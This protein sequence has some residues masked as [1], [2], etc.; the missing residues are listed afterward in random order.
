MHNES[1]RQKQVSKIIQKD[2][3]EIFQI[4]NIGK[5]S[6]VTI[7]AVKSA[8]DLG[9]CRIYVSVF[10]PVKQY[11]VMEEIEKKS[12]MIRSEVGK[13]VRHQFRKVPELEFFVDNTEEEA[14]EVD[15]LIDSLDIP[16]APEEDDENYKDY[17]DEGRL[18]ADDF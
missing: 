1:Q 13:R 14:A 6:L 8:P 18:D 17:K 11:A 2:I 15:Q 7:T 5:D 4:N 12:R 10:P 3:G 9:L 16:P